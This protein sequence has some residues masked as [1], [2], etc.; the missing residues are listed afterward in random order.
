[1]VDAREEAILQRAEE[2]IQRAMALVTQDGV[3]VAEFVKA[4]TYLGYSAQESVK[5]AR[6]RGER[7]VPSEEA[8]AC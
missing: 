5:I 2:D 7:L 1:M 8:S 3:T 4:I 6:S